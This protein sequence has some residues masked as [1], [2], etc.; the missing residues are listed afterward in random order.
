VSGGGG[1]GGGRRF[2]KTELS[3]PVAVLGAGLVIAVDLLS[4]KMAGSPG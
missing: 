4:R 2:P 3:S 1:G